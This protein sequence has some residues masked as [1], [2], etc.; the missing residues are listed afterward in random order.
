MFKIREEALVFHPWEIE[1][2]ESL[3]E[4]SSTPRSAKRFTN[5]YRILKAQVRSGQFAEF[6]GTAQDPGTFQLPMLL[7]AMLLHSSEE[8]KK[9]FPVLMKHA[10][11]NDSKEKV[12]QSLKSELGFSN[13]RDKGLP[14]LER[15]DFPYDPAALLEWIQRVSRFS[16]EVGHE[17]QSFGAGQY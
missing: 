2:A 9:L 11:N 1:F 4:L 14:F 13:L 12:I 15:S 10:E 17:V 16:F 3:F 5:I 8:C 7:L 6:D